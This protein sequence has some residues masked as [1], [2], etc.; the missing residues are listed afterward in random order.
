[1]A[2]SYKKNVKI[3]LRNMEKGVTGR[4]LRLKIHA[5]SAR[6]QPD[7][8]VSLPLRNTAPADASTGAVFI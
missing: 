5:V 7:R 1:M 4:A 3:V 6:E 8:I 2:A